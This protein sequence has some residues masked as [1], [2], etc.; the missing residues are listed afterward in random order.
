MYQS[1]KQYILIKPKLKS[2][3]VEEFNS[4]L[5]QLNQVLAQKH[6]NSDSIVK[7]TIFIKADNNDEYKQ[8]CI[9]LNEQLDNYFNGI[10]PPISI[11]GQP[12]EGQYTCAIEIVLL[13]EKS[14]ITEIKRKKIE[15]IT[16]S[17]IHYSNTKEVYA[18]GLT[19]AFN[20]YETFE[21]SKN[22]F[23]LMVRVLE[24]EHL[25]LGNVVRQW[26]YIE[27]ILDKK[28]TKDGIRQ[29]YQVFN[30][31]RSVNYSKVK[32]DHGYPAATGIGM[33]A[34]GII[35][36]FIAVSPAKNV[37]IVPIKNPQQINA[38][39]YSED[40]LVGKPIKEISQKTSPKFERAKFTAIKNNGLIYVSGTAAIVGQ[41]TVPEQDAKKQTIVT[42]D[43]INK[44][45]SESNLVNHKISMNS[46][47]L[48]LSLLRAYVKNEND[49]KSVKE[50]CEKYY[51][52]VPALYLVS[53]ICRDNLLVE[54][55]GIADWE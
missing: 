2:N 53:D 55:E 11:I 1:D 7:Q 35:L 48:S 19:S 31:V 17:V 27:G 25:T 36:E 3:V 28:P 29:N 14:A 51:P 38:Y 34:G 44:L 37:S 12:V 39:A 42:I 4:C 20:T 8:N 52:N 32:F 23:D 16:Y 5:D 40:V 46:S 15:N 22:A 18:C 49:I 43:N 21:C 26:N 9:Q 6:L 24:A 54:L 10:K 45:I 33:N 13:K 50:V 41:K 30:D 47:P